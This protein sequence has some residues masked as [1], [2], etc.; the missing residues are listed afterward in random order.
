[1]TR[2]ATQRRTRFVLK[3][4][5]PNDEAERR[6]VAPTCNEI[7][8]P[9]HQSTPWLTEDATPRF[10][11]LLDSRATAQRKTAQHVTPNK[12]ISPARVNRERI[13]T[14]GERSEL[15]HPPGASSSRV[16]R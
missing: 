13:Q 7:L 16:M 10:A 1:M 9:N 5:A 3:R 14:F 8:N 11:R 2:Y 15:L 12:T 6:A 4:I